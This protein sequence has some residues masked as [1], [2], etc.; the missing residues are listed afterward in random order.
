VF[1][2]KPVSHSASGTFL[3]AFTFKTKNVSPLFSGAPALFV[4]FS[5]QKSRTTTTQSSGCALSCPEH[6]RRVQKQR[7]GGSLRG[8]ILFKAYFNY[9]AA[10]LPEHE[11]SFGKPLITGS[12][13]STRRQ[14]SSIIASHPRFSTIATPFVATLLNVLILKP[15]KSL[16]CNT[17]EEMWGG[18]GKF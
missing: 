17:Y 14:L 3:P 18:G 16:I 13:V 8:P 10:T 1:P 4:H 5:I 2:R 11:R 7:R 15:L 9:H 6:V 12:L